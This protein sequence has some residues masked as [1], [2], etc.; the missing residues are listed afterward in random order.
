MK[1]LKKI[2]D[3]EGLE[4]NQ[5]CHNAGVYIHILILKFDTYIRKIYIY[6]Y[7]Y[8]CIYQYVTF[9]NPDFSLLVKFQ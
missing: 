2:M 3:F 8:V 9:F 4:V 5:N 1:G 6:I 7:M